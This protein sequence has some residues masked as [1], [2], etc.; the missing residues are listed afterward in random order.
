MTNDQPAPLSTDFFARPTLTVAREL[1]GCRLVRQIDGATLSGVVVEAEAYIGPTDTACHASKGRTP[2]TEVMFGPPG[3][4]YVYLIYGMY[5]MLNL[6]TE[7]E[8]FPA[9]VLIRAVEPQTGLDRM[10]ARRAK[11]G[12]PPLKPAALTSGPGKLC[13]AFGI[14]LAFNGWPVTTGEQ[15]WLERGQTVPDSHVAT[16]PRVGITYAAPEDISAPWRFWL[17]GNPF[18]SG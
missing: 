13:Q 5:H 16:G 4:A 1:L 17:R 2:R 8:D 10:Q 6:V 11:P 7:A 18:V 15:L 14:D 12:R 3:R 9:A